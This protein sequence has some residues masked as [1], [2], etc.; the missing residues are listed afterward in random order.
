[1]TSAS[2]GFIQHHALKLL[3]VRNVH[4]EDDVKISCQTND[5]KANVKLKSENDIGKRL[6]QD[7][8]NFTI[9]R[10]QVSDNKAFICVAENGSAIINLKL[11][12]L[13]VNTGK[14]FCFF[15]LHSG[16]YSSLNEI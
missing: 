10:I 1:M 9:Q 8:Q 2:E 14:M 4:R 16:I 11:G 13:H 6:I 3:Y 7:G 12:S 5:P 15:I